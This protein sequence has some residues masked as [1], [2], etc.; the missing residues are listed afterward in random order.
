MAE[1]IFDYV[2][3]SDLPTALEIEQLGQKHR[4]S[5]SPDGND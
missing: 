3:S 2:S 4:N 1:V 5:T